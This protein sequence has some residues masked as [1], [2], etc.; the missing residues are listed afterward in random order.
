MVSPI[1]LLT[2]QEKKNIFLSPECHIYE[3]RWRLLHCIYFLPVKTHQT[4]GKKK[5]DILKTYLDIANST[6]S[7][8]TQTNSFLQ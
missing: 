5:K 8:E 2:Q 4:S 7:I 3:V 1:F 6:Y